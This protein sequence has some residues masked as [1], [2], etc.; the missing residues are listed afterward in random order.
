MKLLLKWEVKVDWQQLTRPNVARTGITFSIPRMILEMD[1]FGESMCWKIFFC[2]NF[3]NRPSVG[4]TS[5]ISTPKTQIEGS[6][7]FEFLLLIMIFTVTARPFLSISV[8]RYHRSANTLNTAVQ[9]LTRVW[10]YLF[11][12][13]MGM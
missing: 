4:T 8:L 11:H 2:S 1:K 12:I 10:L 6:P 7:L 9:T 5:F 13:Y 3:N